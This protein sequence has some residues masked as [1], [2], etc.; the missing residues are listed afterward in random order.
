MHYF[1]DYII[2]LKYNS[3]KKVNCVLLTFYN[4]CCITESV[5][6]LYMYGVRIILMNGTF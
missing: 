1:D 2:V 6:I 5:G 4:V 3:K